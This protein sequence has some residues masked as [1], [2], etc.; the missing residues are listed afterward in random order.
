M[1]YVQTSSR[2]GSSYALR[3]WLNGRRIRDDEAQAALNA[4][5][6]REHTR[7][8]EATSYGYR[9]TLEAI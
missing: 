2:C 4:I 8:D 9:L 1:K 6:A 5:K 7:R 3:F